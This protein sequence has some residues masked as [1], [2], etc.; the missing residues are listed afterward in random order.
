MVFAAVA[1]S[2]VGGLEE[3]LI[4]G[5]LCL[6]DLN[7]FGPL[8]FGDG[9][10]C[11]KVEERLLLYFAANSTA[12]DHANG[13]IGFVSGTAGQCLAN[14]RA[15]T[16][17]A[18]RRFGCPSSEGYAILWHYSGDSGVPHPQDQGLT[19]QKSAKLPKFSVE[20]RKIGLVC[21]SPSWR[22]IENTLPQKIPVHGVRPFS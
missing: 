20:V 14:I 3:K 11:S 17:E 8:D 1:N 12:L 2:G 6:N 21:E 4:P 15:P 10:A 13:S 16:L 9:K 5:E 22:G 19:D 7:Q 18:S